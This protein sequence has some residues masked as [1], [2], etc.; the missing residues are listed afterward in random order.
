MDGAA[1]GDANYAAGEVMDRLTD[2]TGLGGF[3]YRVEPLP[4]RRMGPAGS[5]DLADA[6]AAARSAYESGAWMNGQRTRFVA[7]YAGRLRQLAAEM[8]SGAK[9]AD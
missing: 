2:E 5:G 1:P 7:A 6:M 4:Y 8:E 3:G 9:P